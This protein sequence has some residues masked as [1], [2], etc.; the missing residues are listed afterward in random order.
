MIF[1]K[2]NILWIMNVYNTYVCIHCIVFTNSTSVS[3]YMKQL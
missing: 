1:L 3:K 2:Y